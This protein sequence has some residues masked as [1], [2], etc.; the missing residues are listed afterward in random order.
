MTN[1]FRPIGRSEMHADNT[2]VV[3]RANCLHVGN[4]DFHDPQ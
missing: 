1:D 4:F 2:D 3:D